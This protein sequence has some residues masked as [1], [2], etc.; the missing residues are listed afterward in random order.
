MEL[1]A[2]T[3]CPDR[4]LPNSVLDRGAVVPCELADILSLLRSFKDFCEIRELHTQHSV[5]GNQ[6]RYVNRSA[7]AIRYVK[8]DA[9]R[10]C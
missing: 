4:S 9:Y 2:G 8:Q 7:Y 1:H 10:T 3:R 6:E 5:G